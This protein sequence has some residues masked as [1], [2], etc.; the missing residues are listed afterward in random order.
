MCPGGF[1]SYSIKLQGLLGTHAIV[2]QKGLSGETTTSMVKRL[3]EVMRI[4]SLTHGQKYSIVCILGGTNDLALYTVQNATTI[5]SRLR[6]LYETVLNNGAKLLIISIP[7]S[8]FKDPQYVQL[9][10]DVNVLITE[11]YMKHKAEGR[12]KY[13]DL[14]AKI[15]FNITTKAP[16]SLWS[17]DGLH[18][19]ALGYDRFGALVFDTISSW[20]VTRKN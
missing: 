6:N 11:Y 4:A 16:T 18:M 20:I 8:E 19:T 14:E 2:D 1:H 13:L 5:F 10:H 7:E 3:P 15:P 9:R 12:V 17:F